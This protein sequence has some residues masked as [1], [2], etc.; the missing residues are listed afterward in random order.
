MTQTQESESEFVRHVPCGS[1][2]SSDANSEYTDGHTYCFTCAAHT[3][4]DKSVTTPG[5]T[6]MA[7]M[8]EGE[9]QGLPLRHI[10][11]ETCK[12]FDYRVGKFNGEWVHIA[13]YY[14][15]KNELVAQHLRTAEKEMPWTGKP[16]DALPFGANVWPKTGKMIVVTEGEIDAMSVSQMQGNKYPVVSIGSGAG[17]QV[18][19]YIAKRLEYFAGFDKVVL[20]FDNDEPGRQATADAA[21]ILGPR[22]HIA[23]FE[24]SDAN[25]MLLAGRQEEVINA[26]WRAKKYTPTDIIEFK[27]LKD[28]AL[29]ETSVGIEYPWPSLSE[30]VRGFKRKELIVISG[31][32]GSG[33]TDF[34]LEIIEHTLRTKNEPVAAFFLEDSPE[35]VYVRLAGKLV[36]KP[37]Y[38]MEDS[39]EATRVAAEEIDKLDLP[40][41]YIYDSGS[42]YTWD[43][44]AGRIEY[45]CQ[46]E[47]VKTV[48]LDHVTALAADMVDERKAL[49]SLMKRAAGL[50]KA[51]DITL[52]VVS[53]LATPDSGSH[54]EG[55]RIMLRHLRGSRAISFW[56]HGCLALERDQQADTEEE[57]RTVF[58]RCLKLRRYSRA[59][60]K[61]IY[62]AYNFETGKLEEC[63]GMTPFDKEPENLDRDF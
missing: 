18:G 48:V 55:A 24:L 27:D 22:A 50:A 42:A 30:L 26:M 12:K 19:K 17:P 39:K 51:L 34:L 6:H 23:E 7:G 62:L 29:A 53:H 63:D 60:G 40:P 61:G 3:S 9:V 41:F 15:A 21:A 1:C 49:D 2:G 52:F 31:A 13:P 38:S 25:D 35:E 46:A 54:E 4:G 20:M 47:G 36:N 5:R 16:K 43:D 10:S 45:L 8:I 28:R 44:I 58:V 37:L 33:K 32:T 59:V 11:E 56:A 14:N 57:R